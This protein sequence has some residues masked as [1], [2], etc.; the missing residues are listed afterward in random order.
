MQS[1]KLSI[2]ESLSIDKQYLIRF[3][4]H[5]KIIINEVRQPCDYIKAQNLFRNDLFAFASYVNPPCAL[6][7]TK[8]CLEHLFSDSTIN[9]HLLNICKFRGHATSLSWTTFQTFS[10]LLSLVPKELTRVLGRLAEFWDNVACLTESKLKIY[11]DTKSIKKVSGLW[12]A[13]CS[14][15]KKTLRELKNS[16]FPGIPKKQKNMILDYIETLDFRVPTMGLVI[17]EATFFLCIAKGVKERLKADGNGF[18]LQHSE[19]RKDNKTVLDED[20]YLHYFLDAAQHVN[21]SRASS[22]H[23]LQNHGVGERTTNRRRVNGSAT[24]WRSGTSIEVFNEKTLKRIQPRYVEGHPPVCLLVKDFL[25]SFWGP[26]VLQD[27]D[28]KALQDKRKNRLS[29]LMRASDLNGS[30]QESSEWNSSNESHDSRFILKPFTFE[31]QAIMDYRAR[32][33]L[34]STK[35]PDCASEKGEICS[36]ETLREVHLHRSKEL[37]PVHIRTQDVRLYSESVQAFNNQYKHLPENDF[38]ESSSDHEGMV[39]HSYDFR[40]QARLSSKTVAKVSFP[41]GSKNDVNGF[42]DTLGESYGPF[43]ISCLEDIDSAKSKRFHVIEASSVYSSGDGSTQCS[44]IP[45]S[46][47]WDVQTLVPSEKEKSVDERLDLVEHQSKTE[48]SL[49]E[50]LGIE[51]A[52][53]DGRRVLIDARCKPLRYE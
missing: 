2:G 43:R 3:D 11:K 39:R 42:A 23:S 40:R 1:Y 30:T 38:E 52:Q 31:S 33:Q 21:H 20:A 51:F 27:L 25:E 44:S 12:P 41:H 24:F 37:G 18:R 7:R 22:R 19:I 6:P 9:K 48:R 32:R 53:I 15:D 34:C 5:R 14:A 47:E 46:S 49:Y 36:P 17:S 13:C 28:E 29:A 16:I 26:S 4:A 35:A 50:M 8:E 10:E 45:E